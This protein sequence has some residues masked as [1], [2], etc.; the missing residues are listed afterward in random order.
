M[1]LTL[2]K[3]LYQDALTGKMA[4]YLQ[5]K[6]LDGYESLKYSGRKECV[7]VCIGLGRIKVD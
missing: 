3:N 5:V 2:K 7:C 6:W 1:V 4:I